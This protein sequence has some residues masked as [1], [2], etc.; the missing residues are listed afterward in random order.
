MHAGKLDRFI[1]SAAPDRSD[2]LPLF[3]TLRTVRGPLP[4]SSQLLEVVGA[5]QRTGTRH[6]WTGDTGVSGPGN[7]RVSHDSAPR[8]FA[9][10]AAITELADE[11]GQPLG[12]VSQPVYG[13]PG[14]RPRSAYSRMVMAKEFVAARVFQRQTL[15]GYGERAGRDW[16][17]VEHHRGAAWRG[18]A[19]RLGDE[20]DSSKEARVSCIAGA[21]RL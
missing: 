13:T 1:H 18:A 17:L 14:T 9:R 15:T 5:G 8:E 10:A 19:V 20:I 12:N 16:R 6:E 11:L 4:Q 7:A 3:K 2:P 21:N